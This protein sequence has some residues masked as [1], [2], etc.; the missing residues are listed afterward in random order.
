MDHRDH[1]TETQLRNTLEARPMD[2]EAGRRSFLKSL[3]IAAG[4]AVLGSRALSET[5][6]A[7][8][9]TDVDILNFAL[10]LEYLEAEFYL[11]AAYGDGLD[12]ADTTGT[13]T[14]GDVV[15]GKTV[16]FVT[17]AI[18]NYAKEIAN[19]ER[20]HVLFLRSALGSAKV[21]RPKIN[22]R[23]S[24]TAAARAAGLIDNSSTFSPF[25]N[26]TAFLIGAFI[27]EDV[28][29]TAYKGAARLLSNKDVLEA[30]AGI[31]AVE[32]YHAGMIRTIMYSKSMFDAAKAVSNLRDAVDG[33]ADKDQGIG[34]KDRSNIVLA[35]E[36]GIAF[37]RSAN[38]VLKIVYLGSSDPG[39][40]FPNGLNGAIA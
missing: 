19:D 11:R 14:R 35:D 40:F 37:S 8:T 20:K 18:R 25:D 17:P 26:E 27:F 39:G 36:N 3:G 32:A 5:A 7:Q 23:A 24:F 6:E 13:G 15:G 30:A 16:P 4:A 38:Q 12:F 22:L 29:V 9:V 2:W 33:A 31:L 28:G 34:N 1:A 21:A 10:N